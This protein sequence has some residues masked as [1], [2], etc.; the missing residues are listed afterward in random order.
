M[1]ADEPSF[2]CTVE[3]AHGGHLDLAV[4]F[5]PEGQEPGAYERR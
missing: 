4:R 1:S 2:G 3:A 5:V